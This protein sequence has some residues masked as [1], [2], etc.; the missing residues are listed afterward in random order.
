MV[1]RNVSYVGRVAHS[2]CE[3]LSV[4]RFV[5]VGRERF[6]LIRP[7]TIYLFEHEER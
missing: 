6:D 7:L 4:L 2:D 1:T 5:Y 3:P